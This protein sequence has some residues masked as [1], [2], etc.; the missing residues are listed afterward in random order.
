MCPAFA[1]RKVPGTCQTIQR[2]IR[3]YLEGGSPTDAVIERS[4]LC[5]ECFL[6]VTDTCPQGLDPMR[7]NQLL[8][9]LLNKEG[10][11]PLPFIPPSDPASDERVVASL[12]TTGE[13]YLRITTPAV[14]G[15]GRILFFPGCNI[16]Y[17]PNLLLT[18]LDLLDLVVEHWTY[19]PGLDNCCGSNYDSAGRLSEGSRA[20]KCLARAMMEKE[21]EKIVVWCSTCA[22]RLQLDGFEKPVITF[23]RLIA[24]ELGEMP[25]GRFFGDG[26]TLQ[27]PCKDAYM[28]MD[29]MA[30]REVLRLVTGEPPKEMTRH[31]KD[32]VCCGWA[33][34]KHRPEIWEEELKKRLAEAG[35]TGADTLATV[36]HGCQWIMDRTESQTSVRVR[37]YITLAGE[38]VGI[39]HPERFR[40]LRVLGE[41]KMALEALRK[42][43][44]D[45]FERLPYEKSRILKAVDMILGSFY[46]RGA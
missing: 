11:R 22:V 38:S 35:E 4:Q 42:E 1:H 34:R 44:G 8:R 2:D 3:S 36:C 28:D 21:F 32:T 10:A 7:F 6:C 19:L 27:E 17:Q 16:Y 13:E 24:D 25:Q 5:N 15:D 37:N 20:I 43:I 29:P 33:L 18:A 46:G 31:G 14:K 26:V 40:E 23:A 41:R 45:P 39:H 9:G 12:I 30:P